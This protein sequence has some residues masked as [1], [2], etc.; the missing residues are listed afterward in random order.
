MPSNRLTLS[1]RV[2]CKIHAVGVLRRVSKTANNV[3]FTLRIDVLRLKVI[4]DI[5]AERM[6]RK[7]DAHGIGVGAEAD[8]SA[9]G[10]FAPSADRVADECGFFIGQTPENLLFGIDHF[11]ARNIVKYAKKN[12][13]F[14]NP[15]S[16][17]FFKYF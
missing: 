5:H 14:Y 3:L 11:H 10:T 2:G 12:Y 17:N 8:T 13:V 6:E 15:D 4:F 16:S 9:A 1:I 7:T